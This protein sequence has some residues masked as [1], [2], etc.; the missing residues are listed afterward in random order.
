A[1]FTT[2]I[3][4]NYGDLIR[5]A[6]IVPNKGNYDEM[7]M[8]WT[9]NIIDWTV[10]GDKKTHVDVNP[11][12]IGNAIEKPTINAEDKVI[13]VGDKFD[14]LEGVSATDGEGN[15]LK[16]VVESNTVDSKKPGSYKVKYSATDKYGN[17]AEKTITVTVT[18]KDPTEKPTIYAENKTI[19]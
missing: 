10:I 13:N 7:D 6:D 8:T 9:T 5:D 18:A 19:N 11:L 12:V 15:P 17:K 3:T 4:F 16:V 2:D 14:P 1:R